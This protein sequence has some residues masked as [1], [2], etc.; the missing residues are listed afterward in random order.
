MTPFVSLIM[1]TRNRAEYIAAGAGFFLGTA[2]EDVELIVC[3]ASDS[4]ALCLQA[5][6]PWKQDKR[7]RVIDNSL[8]TTGHLSSMAENW[9]RALDS[10]Q[11]KWVIIIGDDDVCD[12]EVVPFIGRLAQAAPQIEAL[13]WHRAHFDI[14]ID[15]PR[16]AKVPMGT[17]IMLAAAKDSVLKQVTWPNEKRPPTSLCSPYHGA[18]KRDAL[19]RLKATRGRWFSFSTP[20][21][22]LGWSLAWQVQQFAISERPF[23]IAG[24]SPKSNSYSVRNEAKR[25]EYL[26]NWHSESG[27]LDG[28]GATTDPFL[29]T[30]PMTV[31]GFRNAFC[32]AYGIQQG[33]HLPHLVSTLANS[34]Q[35]QEDEDSFEQHRAAAIQFLMQHFGQDFGFAALHRHTRPPEPYAGLAGDQ[36]VVPNSVFGGDIRRFAEVAFGLV[37]PV[38]HLMSQKV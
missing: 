36:L 9:S 10:A 5:L 38:S 12:P 34:L 24:V 31:L 22:D 17:Q 21:Y 11:G 25:A 35:N 3:D 19:L 29:F 2:R 6:E 30:L 18:V 8:D 15:L 26:A 23:S 27:H 28:W 32:A 4:H 7:L 13:T 16:E 37:R 14:G 20:D 1:P 33:I